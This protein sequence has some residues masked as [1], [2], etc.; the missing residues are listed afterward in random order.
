MFYRRKLGEIKCEC[1]SSCL[2]EKADNITVKNTKKM[3]L[4]LQNNLLF[5]LETLGV[6][7]AYQ[8]CSML[9]EGDHSVRS[10]WIEAKENDSNYSVCNKYL[11][12]SA[13]MLGM[14]NAEGPNA[15]TSSIV[16]VLEEPFF[17]R[18]LLRLVEILSEFRVQ[19]NMNCIIFVKRIV[20]AKSLTCILRSLSILSFWR[21]DFLIGAHSG[22]GNKSR[23]NIYS[24]LEKFRSGKLNLLVATKVGEE[25]LDIQTCCLV[26]RFDLPETV[27][28][29][30]Q[31]RGRARMPQSEYA[32]LVDRTS[33]NEMNLLENFMKEEDEMNKE[34]ARRTSSSTFVD[35]DE[36]SYT[37]AS[38]GATVSR[39]LSVSLLYH[40]CA[41]L[42]RD[43]YFTPKP[44]LLYFNETKMI[45]CTIILPSNAPIHKIIGSPQINREEAKKDA[46]LK[47][48]KELH[49]LGALTDYLL[50]EQEDENDEC[51][52][53]CNSEDSNDPISRRELHEMLVPAILKEPWDF[54]E[55]SISLNSYYMKL[56]PTP[57]DRVYRNFGLFLKAPLPEEAEKMK[58]DLCLSHGR[59]VTSELLPFGL[60]KFDQDE[61]L[62]AQ[63]FQKILLKAIH[64]RSELIADFFTLDKDEL[65]NPETSTFYLLLPVIITEYEN[66]MTVDWC[67][68]RRSLSSPMF[69]TLVESRNKV[70]SLNNNHL[71][72]ANGSHSTDDVVNSL[73]YVPCKKAF[74]FIADVVTDKNA[75]S[76]YKETSTHIQHYMK[77]FKIEFFYPDQP[78]LKA[79]RVFAV[80]NLL[81]KGGYS[82]SRKKEEH[83]I[84]LPPEICQL[85]IIG[86]SKDIGS[87]M[88]LL[89]SIMHRLENFLVAIEL[90]QRLTSSFSEGAEVTAARVLEALT[91]EKCCEHFSLER[92]EVLGDAFLKFAVGR[93]LFLCHDSLD[94]G[95]L[96]KK[97]SNIVKNS[98]LLKL[99]TMK[100]L[101][102]YIRDQPFE[103][104]QFFA[105]GRPCSVKCDKDKEH[106]IHSPKPG[107][108]H[109]VNAEIRCSKGHHWLYKKTIADVVEALIGAFIVDSGFKAATAFLKWLGIQLDFDH[110]Q[111]SKICRASKVFTPLS[112]LKN[113][114]SLES[115]IGYHFL[116]QG[117]LVQAFIHPS[118]NNPLGG[119]YQRL[120]FL[121]DAVLDYLITSYLYS[122]YPKLKPGQLTD[123]RSS[124]VNNVTFARVAV[125][126]SFQ[127]FVL[128]DCMH[129]SSSMDKYVDFIRTSSMEEFT[130]GPNCPKIL[131][132]IVESFIGAILLDTGFD[133]NRVWDIVISFMDP[134]TKLQINPL[135]ELVELCQFYHW[136]LQLPAVE[137]DGR[138]VIEGKVEGTG[139]LET[140]YSINLN[141]KAGQRAVSEQLFLKLKAK[142]YRC[143]SR[144]L[145]EILNS[146]SKME[147]KLIGYDEAAI[148][149]TDSGAI[150]INNLK[151]E[152]SPPPS[153]LDMKETT[154]SKGLSVDLS[155]KSVLYIMC[156]ANCWKPPYFECIS[157]SGACH[158]KEFI[159][160]VIVDIEEMS[161]LVVAFG[162]PRS[163]KKDAAEHAAEGAVWCLRNLG[164]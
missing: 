121:G 147:A 23:K 21:C 29:F 43:E 139:V 111:V 20:I 105:L 163:R 65:S 104:C 100:K 152:E 109:D 47:A 40:Y 145:E 14:D 51:F 113:I 48:C 78:L 98:N 149:V 156:G 103:P 45:V 90:K 36:K 131:G 17:S 153:H 118:Y 132:D 138:F 33:M 85:K 117:L 9:M 24:I 96:T 92:L 162:E 102:V 62:Q 83:F 154:K 157:E 3:L 64:D 71:Q 27:S 94:E 6:R 31:S 80:D 13:D 106:T 63:W 125:N 76:L 1:V 72:L 8:A 67:L 122:V 46:C 82:V 159:F 129:L 91:T 4:R 123:L 124:Y 41:K 52:D 44:E 160:K 143:K 140:A 116:Y 77:K 19:Q 150:P 26:V 2:N 135:R 155:S 66:T 74:F 148:D 70:I 50:P 73:I 136:D 144:S 93:Y 56:S 79:K 81:R 35:F 75:Y 137:K 28:S 25:G 58:L 59:T 49:E 5:C 130:E 99:A 119:C 95:K 133:L 87:S 16:D 37:V 15:V 115:S 53:L 55:N 86:L 42:P 158:L 18:K 84:E 57:P 164:Y 120:E 97:R 89:P 38:S 127:Q 112:A 161:Q 134:F 108:E 114:A 88:Y 126:K 69:R 110:S 7:G 22:K 128:Y 107:M 141:K 61:M 34:I 11:N 60:T 146:A 142:G 10:K 32:L 68:M 30:I 12:Q 101:Q 151:I 39:A 54:S